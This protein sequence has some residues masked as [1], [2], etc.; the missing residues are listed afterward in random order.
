MKKIL[1]F[2][3]IAFFVSGCDFFKDRDKLLTSDE[4]IMYSRLI[5]DFSDL[6][7]LKTMEYHKKNKRY[8]V[9]DFKENGIIRVTE[10][11]EEKYGNAKWSWSSDSKE[12]IL[13]SKGDSEKQYEIF[14]LSESKLILDYKLGSRTFTEE[15]RHIDNDDWLDDDID[16]L[17]EHMKANF[18]DSDSLQ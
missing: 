16:R 6:E 5:F 15:Y 3:G 4:W 1:L 12:A 10:E 13:L 9:L 7:H 14:K 17:N 11:N 2:F 18:N 8:V